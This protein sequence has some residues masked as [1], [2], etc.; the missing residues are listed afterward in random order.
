MTNSR[1]SDFCFLAPDFLSGQLRQILQLE[2]PGVDGHAEGGMYASPGGARTS[3][4]VAMPP[5]AV[6]SSVVAARKR[7][8]QSRS[9]SCSMP[10]LST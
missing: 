3:S 10:S 4:I 1:D 2:P 7:R 9:V 5:V 6:I 8:N